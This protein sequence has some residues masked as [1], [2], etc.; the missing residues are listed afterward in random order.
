MPFF[1]DVNDK[2]RNPPSNGVEAENRRQWW[3]KVT[4]QFTDATVI[5]AL[6][7]DGWKLTGG[8]DSRG[9][10]IEKKIGY[11][12]RLTICCTWDGQLMV[13]ESKES[14]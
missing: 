2:L 1:F 9:V 8:V 4:P 3:G 14:W 12:R 7:N 5:D 13:T 6:L 10:Y 11:V